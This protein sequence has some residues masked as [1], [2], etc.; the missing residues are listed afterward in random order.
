[1]QEKALANP[2]IEFI[3]KSNLAEVVGDSK[4]HAARVV[5]VEDGGETTV[6]VDGVFMYVG[7]EPNSEMVKGLVELDEHG[8]IVT[9]PDF[10]TSVPGI[11]AAGDVRSGSIKQVIVAAGEGAQA[12]MNAQRY[13][14]RAAGTAYE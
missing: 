4:V 14:E 6:P 3:W 11:F 7:N 10:A 9:G 2:K 5:N 8:Y 13:V 12:A 1:V